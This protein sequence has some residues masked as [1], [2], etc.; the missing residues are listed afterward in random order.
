MR[1]YVCARLNADRDEICVDAAASVPALVSLRFHPSLPL[2]SA[3]DP[4]T[5]R[6]WVWTWNDGGELRIVARTGSGERNR[7]RWDDWSSR[8]RR[9]WTRSA[10]H[11]TLPLLAQTTPDGA[12]DLWS[13]DG[14]G[15]G[16]T[17]RRVCDVAFEAL[18]LG[19]THSGDALWVG[20]Y[21]SSQL[22]DLQGQVVA[23]AFGCDTDIALH[24]EG[25]PAATFVSDQGATLLHI[26]RAVEA[27]ALAL[28]DRTLIIDVDGYEGLVFSPS[29]DR[30]PMMGNAYEVFASVYAFPS[31]K[32]E[33][34][35]PI[36]E[37]KD[38]YAQVPPPWNDYRWSLGERLAL[39]PDGAS[40]LIG[41]FGG[42]LA[43]LKL[44]AE[45]AL[46]EIWNAHA[47]PIGA[48]RTRPHDGLLATSDLNGHLRLFQMPQPFVGPD[49][50]K[51]PLTAIYLA[52]SRA[53]PLD[54]D[55]DDLQLTDGVR[56]WELSRIGDEPL[57]DDAPTWAQLAA[58][59]QG[60]MG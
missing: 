16:V 55:T 42:D 25:E 46:G 17:T 15:A 10:W 27:Q 3:L 9:S 37:W 53:V 51:R 59:L 23:P 13:L 21:G 52:G 20:A 31:L 49:S 4:L 36:A 58:A 60:R 22:V 47:G 50:S 44:G 26:V 6:G 40:L 57:A 30:F 7:R 41:G 12:I 18:C 38:L 28:F 29:G 48:L 5:D 14:N 8:D 34:V 35:L 11:P 1:A 19:F 56:E 24:P 32:R 39:T 33:L 45:P 54:T 2:L 43:V